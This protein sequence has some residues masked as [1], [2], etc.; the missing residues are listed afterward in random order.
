MVVTSLWWSDKPVSNVVDFMLFFFLL[1]RNIQI[2]FHLTLEILG[3]LAKYRGIVFNTVAEIVILWCLAM[4]D[5]FCQQV[6]TMTGT[7]NVFS[8]LQ[9]LI[10]QINNPLFFLSPMR[11]NLFRGV[12]IICH[13][14]TG[15]CWISFRILHFSWMVLFLTFLF[16]EFSMFWCWSILGFFQCLHFKCL[17]SWISRLQTFEYPT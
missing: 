7:L 12:V 17:C 13:R 14:S 16:S 1:V 11:S 10:P 15:I 2:I 6:H 4:C 3:T 8:F 9:N 5:M